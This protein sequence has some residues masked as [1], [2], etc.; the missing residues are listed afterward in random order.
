MTIKPT[1]VCFDEQGMTNAERAGTRARSRE[2]RLMNIL[3]WVLQGTLAL[4]YGSGG[5]YKVFAFD[6]LAGQ[7]SALPRAGWSAIGGL[8]LV[9]AVL[10]IVPSALKWR[11]SLTPLAAAVL[12]LESLALAGLYAS[13]SV[14][15]AASNP[16][17]WSVAMALM[18]AFVAY[19]R[20]TLRPLV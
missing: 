11:P 16:L 3:L 1:N 13:Y 10:L 12:A 9:G 17:T 2:P 20:S 14:E 19:G 15:V 5:A 8:E 6:E 7:L 4:L 18:A